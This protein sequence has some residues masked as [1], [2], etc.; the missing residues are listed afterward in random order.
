MIEIPN[1]PV[2]IVSDLNGRSILNISE[3]SHLRADSNYTF[4]HHINKTFVASRTLKFF[5]EQVSSAHFIR[6]HQSYSVNREF[7]ASWDIKN[8]VITLVNGLEIPIARAR[9]KLVQK[10]LA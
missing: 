2:L 5:Q 1:N 3:I 6:T 4:I 7:I 10:L 8:R 9:R